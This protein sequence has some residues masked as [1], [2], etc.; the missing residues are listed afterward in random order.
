MTVHPRDGE[1]L[2]D[3]PRLRS[4]ACRIGGKDVEFVVGTPDPLNGDVV[5]EIVDLG[6]AQHYDVYTANDPKVPA[7]SIGRHI[8][9][10]VAAD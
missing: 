1:A 9:G 2:G 4:I 3:A 10:V 7:L 6:R 5:L 8:Y